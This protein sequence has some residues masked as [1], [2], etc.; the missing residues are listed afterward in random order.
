[1]RRGD[2]A[3]EVEREER[4]GRARQDAG[5]DRVAAG[6]GDPARQRGLQLGTGRTRVATHEDAPA[7]GPERGGA[8]Q[9][10]DQLG[11]QVLADNATDA[12]RAE[13]PAWHG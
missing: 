6:G 9:T 7:T 11:R 1:V 12:V 3:A 5:H 10:L 4:D 13:V 2:D 8:A